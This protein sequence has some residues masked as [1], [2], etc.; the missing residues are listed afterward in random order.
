MVAGLSSVEVMLRANASA[1]SRWVR[2][3]RF[4]RM[5]VGLDRIVADALLT[6]Y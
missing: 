1:R 2:A 5:V 3:A 6:S 4:P